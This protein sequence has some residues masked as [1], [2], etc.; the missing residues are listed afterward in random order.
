M[1]LFLNKMFFGQR[2][3]G[4]SAAGQVFFNKQL[5]DLTIAET[6]TLA[7]VLPAP[8]TY[9][10]VRNTVSATN[11]RGYVLGRM[12]PKAPRFR[13]MSSMR[14]SRRKTGAFGCIRAS[15]IAA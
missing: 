7:G 12:H 4:V 2:A 14:L 6:A 5:K 13:H 10:P 8:S 11:R 1:E 15:T 3:Y 9:N